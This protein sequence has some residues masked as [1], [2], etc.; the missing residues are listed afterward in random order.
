MTVR[1]TKVQLSDSGQYQCK[2]KRTLWADGWRFIDSTA[3]VKIHVSKAPA[4]VKP[5]VIAPTTAVRPNHSPDPDPS[6]DI[7][8]SP[9]PNYGLSTIT[10]EQEVSA[11]PQ[12]STQTGPLLYV[13]VT[14]AVILILFSV[15]LLLFYCKKNQNKEVQL[16]AEFEEVFEGDRE[17]EEIPEMQVQRRF[18]SDIY[19]LASASNHT[20][21]DTVL[22]SEVSFT[23]NSA[24][25]SRTEEVLYSAVQTE[26]NPLYITV[27]APQRINK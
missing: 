15:A 25:H 23:G 13:G 11:A 17:Y 7:T 12:N 19:S 14:F 22:Y 6:P 9:D 10:S 20:Q 27:S 24:P 4:P 26:D 16:K 2:L 8:P 3:E 18:A 1:I 21:V 5:P